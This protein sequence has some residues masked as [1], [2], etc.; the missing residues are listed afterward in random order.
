LMEAVVTKQELAP[1][2]KAILVFLPGIG[3]IRELND[4][5]AGHPAF[6]G[7]IYP[8]HSSV[9]SEEQQAAF[10]IP[11]DGETKIVLST[12]IAETGVTIPDVTCVIDTGKHREM[13]FDERRQL[14]RLVQAFISKANAK[15]RRGRAG[16]V[17]EGICFHLF[18]KKRHDELLA[19]QQTP[20][21]LRLSLQDLAMRV[22][23]SGLGDIEE[24]LGFALDPPSPKNIRR[25]IDQLIEVAPR[26]P[27]TQ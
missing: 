11:P 9:S 4:M 1:Y 16:R 18:T 21:M 13:R 12:N 26:V 8:L 17:Q 27:E 10:E 25:A 7:R 22:K 5:L 6:T 2:S 14:S 24:T 15:Q 19:P 20:E 23:I 3:E